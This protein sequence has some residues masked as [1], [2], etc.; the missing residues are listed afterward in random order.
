MKETA[1]GCGEERYA[2]VPP[3]CAPVARTRYQRGGADSASQSRVSSQS[4]LHSMD[5][6]NFVLVQ[7]TQNAQDSV[8]VLSICVQGCGGSESISIP[9]QA[10]RHC[11]RLHSQRTVAPCT[12]KQLSRSRAQQARKTCLFPFSLVTPNLPGVI[13]S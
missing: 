11:F 1:A 8:D 6:Q 4:M 10:G 3:N 12:T 7:V 13:L 2:R 5:S 9:C